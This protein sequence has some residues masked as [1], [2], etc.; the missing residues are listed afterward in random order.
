MRNPYE[1]L[2]VARDASEA[3]IKKAFRRLAKKYHPDSN[4][5][6]TT[7]Q[8]KFSSINAAYEIVGDKEKRAKFDRGEI[9]AEGK[10]AFHGF[11]GFGGGFGGERGGAREFRYSAENM[12][13]VG[14][15][16]ILSQILGGFG[17]RE[18]SHQARG[19]AHQAQR[20]RGEDAAITVSMTLEDIAA[21]K[22]ARVT[23]PNGKTVD[24]AV[25]AGIEPGQQIRLKGQ[26][27]PGQLG[28][29]AGDALVTV[30]F[31]PHKLFRPEG[32]NLRLDLPVSLDEAVLGAKIRV[33]T[34][35]G[36]VEMAVPAGSSGGKTMRLRGK[37]L[38]KA[39][40]GRGDLLVQ[41]KI[42]LP[43]EA[44]P[45]LEALMHKWREAKR[46]AARGEEFGAAQ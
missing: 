15:D 29:P 32:A 37:G 7:A 4:P 6:D 38:P 9:D 22:K 33:P 13:D 45:E 41:L 20:K 21:G 30:E 36:A 46:Y 2:G 17:R 31:A 16:D 35:E 26:G 14:M 28:G 34:L 1:V 3:D 10:P 18:T 25:P 11:E 12:S 44:D 19:G 24:A 39:S 40:G 5:G 8:E 27:H 43:D 23:L 42:V